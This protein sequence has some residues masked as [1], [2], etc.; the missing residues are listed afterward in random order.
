MGS[1]MKKHDA[2]VLHLPIREQYKKAV[3]ISSGVG[4][5]LM[6]HYPD[7]FK[8]VANIDKQI[9]QLEQDVEVFKRKHSYLK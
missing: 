5:Y 8:Q 7:S 4:V 9:K 1:F 2:N 6:E 3:G